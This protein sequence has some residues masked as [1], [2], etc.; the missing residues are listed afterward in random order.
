MPSWQIHNQGVTQGREAT[1]KH[2]SLA[3]EEHLLITN[4]EI[5]KIPYYY[6][7]HETTAGKMTPK[8]S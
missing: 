1:R 4:T 3:L 5:T 7:S 6:L 2:L 8:K